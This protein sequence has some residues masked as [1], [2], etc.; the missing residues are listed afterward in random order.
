MNINIR[1]I[2]KNKKI[3]IAISIF[4]LMSVFA[5]IASFFFNSQKKEKSSEPSSPTTEVDPASGKTITLFTG[6]QGDDDVLWIGLPEMSNKGLPYSAE[7]NVKKIFREYMKYDK[8]E[9]LNRVSLYKGSHLFVENPS[10]SSYHTMKFAINTDK[11]DVY[12]KV[13]LNGVENYSMELF[14]DKEMTDKLREMS[15]CSVLACPEVIP[16]GKM[17]TAEE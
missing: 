15:Y 7:E 5:I 6:A 12:M 16:E 9:D 3:V 17:L 14:S 11:E 2:L 8:K 4:I 13:T 1:D 10:G